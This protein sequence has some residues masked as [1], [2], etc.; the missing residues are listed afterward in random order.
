MTKMES[1]NHLLENNKINEPIHSCDG[2]KNCTHCIC[3]NTKTKYFC[4]ID[5]K[6]NPR[7]FQESTTYLKLQLLNKLF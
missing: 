4:V 1:L 3:K 6:V 5:G 2:I 7:W